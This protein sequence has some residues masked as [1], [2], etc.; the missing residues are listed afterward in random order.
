MEIYRVETKVQGDG[1][2]TL[3]GLPFQGGDEV[4]VIVRARRQ[5]CESRDYPLRG[6]P[7]RYL[8]PFEGVDTDEWKALQ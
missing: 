1:T 2:L 6:K 8:W 3:Q 5:V 4:E 7:V